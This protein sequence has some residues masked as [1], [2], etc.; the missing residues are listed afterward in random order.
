M[1]EL[2]IQNK[3]NGRT[4]VADEG[5]DSGIRFFVNG[6]ETMRWLGT[7]MQTV[8][9]H[10][11]NGTVSL[12]YMKCVMISQYLLRGLSSGE[13]Q[14]SAKSIRPSVKTVDTVES[15]FQPSS[16]HCVDEKRGAGS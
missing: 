7:A 4:W 14:A 10:V 1:A 3:N 5:H 6:G 9:W 11:R 15:L 12:W 2:F 13:I 8:G 16:K